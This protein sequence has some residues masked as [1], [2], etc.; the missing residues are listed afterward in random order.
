ML[1]RVRRRKRVDDEAE[2]RPTLDDRDDC[3]GA[4][5]SGHKKQHNDDGMMVLHHADGK[6]VR[7]EWNLVPFQAMAERGL[8]TC[9]PAATP[10]EAVLA[11]VNH[12][13]GI[14]VVPPEIMGLPAHLYECMPFH[15]GVVVAMPIPPPPNKDPFAVEI[16][17]VVLPPV[18]VFYRGCRFELEGGSMVFAV[19]ARESWCALLVA[20]APQRGRRHVDVVR[21]NCTAP[22]APPDRAVDDMAES[23]HMA[24]LAVDGVTGDV[25]VAR[26]GVHTIAGGVL[27]FYT[28]PMG[29]LRAPAHPPGEGPLQ[30]GGVGSLAVAHRAPLDALYAFDPAMKECA[31]M[32]VLHTRAVFV[33]PRLLA[34]EVMSR[35]L[36]VEPSDAGNLSVRASAMGTD[37]VGCGDLYAGPARQSMLWD[38]RVN[39]V[40]TIERLGPCGFTMLVYDEADDP[41]AAEPPA[42]VPDMHVLGVRIL[43]ISGSAPRGGVAIFCQTAKPPISPCV[44]VAHLPITAPLAWQRLPLPA[45]SPAVPTTTEALLW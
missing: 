6:G 43:P 27:T 42:D 10:G 14:N 2:D 20:T 3:G 33:A 44:W 25:A 7:L 30:L 13:L 35:I 21:F 26:H 8:E 31:G 41:W 22:A 15:D 36:L 28:T 39:M 37:M 19:S 23:C 29:L 45:Y 38:A 12:G 32:F 34:M 5:A 17:P 4:S 16:G 9:Y 11:T 24:A 18:L 40:V 1:P